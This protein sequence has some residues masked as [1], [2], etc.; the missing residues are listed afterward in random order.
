MPDFQLDCD[1]RS[2]AFTTSLWCDRFE[3]ADQIAEHLVE[4]R[5]GPYVEPSEEEMR[6][7]VDGMPLEK[8]WEQDL[9][10]LVIPLSLE[11]YWETFWADDAPYYLLSKPRDPDDVL[12]SNTDWSTDLT[13]GYEERSGKPVLLERIYER[14]LRVRGNIF[15]K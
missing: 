7:L 1:P 15:V 2:D 4:S 5:K 3:D 9:E 12:L 8:G 11:E 14:T 13:P 10:T 6:A